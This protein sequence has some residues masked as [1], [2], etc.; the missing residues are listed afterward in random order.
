MVYS[1]VRLTVGDGCVLDLGV[2]SAEFP[3][4]YKQNWIHSDIYTNTLKAS[5]NLTSNK[6]I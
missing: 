6:P 2:P 5:Q 4:D 3:A 1:R